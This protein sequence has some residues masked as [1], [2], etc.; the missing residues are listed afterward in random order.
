MERKRKPGSLRINCQLADASPRRGQRTD[1]YPRTKR[2]V[3][4]DEVKHAICLH[5]TPGI[6]R[7]FKRGARSIDGVHGARSRRQQLS[8]IATPIRIC[9]VS[10]TLRDFPQVVDSEDR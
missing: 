1:R 8:V 9:D 10:V 2:P 7:G 4:N 3:T 5:D 6:R